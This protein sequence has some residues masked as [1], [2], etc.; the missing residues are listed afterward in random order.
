MLFIFEERLWGGL[1]LIKLQ[2]CKVYENRLFCKV[3]ENV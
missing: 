2:I 3:Y 1:F